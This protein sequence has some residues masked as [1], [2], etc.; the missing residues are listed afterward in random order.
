MTKAIA[1]LATCLACLVG[2][3]AQ[4]AT[5][6]FSGNESDFTS[7]GVLPTQDDGIDTQNFGAGC[8]YPLDIGRVYITNDLTKVYVGFQYKRYCFCDINL[9]WAFQTQVGGQA[10]DPFMRQIVWVGVLPDYIVYDV[11]PTNCNSFNYEV[12]YSAGL[13]GWN[14]VRDGSN[15]LGIVDADGGNFVE[16]ALPLSDLG[17]SVGADC[18]RALGFEVWVTQEGITKPAFDMVANDSEQRST[19]GGTCFDIPGCLPSMP[20]STLPWTL[21]CPTPVTPRAWGAIKALYR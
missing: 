16:L 2:A 1:V 17:L 13:T 5:I 15:G 18:G 4:A 7:Q 9:G 12:L 10:T 3:N 21:E 6:T 11:I 19:P 20:S 8:E 14:T